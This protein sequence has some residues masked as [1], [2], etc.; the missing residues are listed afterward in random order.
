[1]TDFEAIDFFRDTAFVADP[2]PYFEFL[3][4]E[5]TPIGV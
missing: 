3:H 5:F 1:M 2:C 4:L